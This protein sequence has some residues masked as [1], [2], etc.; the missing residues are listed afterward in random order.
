MKKKNIRK[1]RNK[2]SCGYL[3][4]NERMYKGMN[5]TDTWMNADVPCRSLVGDSKASAADLALSAKPFRKFIL[6]HEI[7]QE[8]IWNKKIHSYV[9]PGNGIQM[10]F[11]E[12]EYI[13]ISRKWNTFVF[14]GNG[15]HMYFQEMEYNY[16]Y[17]I[18]RDIR[19]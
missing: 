9:F 14:P 4:V 16:L 8:I 3:S 19:Y 13:C 1:S 15:I 17:N 7:I 10:Y 11:Q 5:L 2:K 18:H 12:M 6:L